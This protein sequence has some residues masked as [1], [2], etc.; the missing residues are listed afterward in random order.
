MAKYAEKADSRA[1]FLSEKEMPECFTVK[2]TLAFFFLSKRITVTSLRT[3]DVR[4]E[5]KQVSVALNTIY[6]DLY[7]YF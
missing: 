6:V 2:M 7:V 5:K 3:L 1:F 4:L